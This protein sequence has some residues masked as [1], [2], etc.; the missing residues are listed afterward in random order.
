MVYRIYVE[1][2]KELANEAKSLLSDIHTLLGIRSVTDLRL[3][4]RY[5]AEDIDAALFDYA[6]KNVFSEPQLDIVSE[7][8]DA[9]GASVF[10]VEY[11][12]GQF[13]Q[14]ADSAA[15][16]IQ[17]ISQGERPT[18]KT[19][20]VYLLY[21]EV[22]DSELA[23]I[24]KYVIN[25]VE[26][27][28][29]SLE[30][31]ET[32]KTKYD[33]PTEVETLDGFTDLDEKGLA[34]FVKKYALAMDEDDIAFCRDYFRKEGRNPTITEIRMIDTYWSDHCR[35]TTFL[36]V[37]DSVKFEDELLQRTY[38]DYMATR[39]ELGRTKPVCLMDIGT[40]AGKY[41]KEKGYLDKLDESEEINACTVKIEVEIDGKKEPWLLLF[42]N[43]TH[44]HP[45]EIEPFGGA[46]TCI[47]GAIRDPLSGRSYV[48]GAMRVTGAS[49]PLKSVAETIP[50]KLPQRKIVTTAAAGYSSYGNQI[51][52]ATGI[53]DELYHDGYTAKRME[54]GAVIAAAP[55]ENV[56]RECPQDGDV[57]ILLGGAT[58]RDGCGG[59]T[60]SSKSHTTESLESC[61]AEVQKGNAPEERK[62]QR[63][64]RN[65]EA[66]RMIK[67]C[68]DFG[69]GGVSVAI[70]ELA[71][72]LEIDLN[73][74]PKK[75][76]GLDGTELAIS[77]SQERMAV[78]IEKENVED[79]LT[80]AKEENLN[81]TVVAKVK[82]EKRLTMYWNGKAI[83]DLSREF[84]NSNGA[85]KHI[86]IEAAASKCPMK[87]IEGNFA[88]N[89]KKLAGDLNV[90][91]K[92]GLS[93]RFDSTIGA[94]TVLMPFG[95]KNQL[96]PIQA[97]VQL[98]STEKGHTD[99]CSLMSWGYNPFYTE[100]TPFHGAYMAVVES[101]CKLIATGAKFE[102]VYLTFQEYFERP[103][104]DPKRW[105]KPLSAL[106]GAFKVQKDL[107]V[108]AIGG[109]DSMSG[110]FEN[111]D[112]PP[113]LVS[114]AVTTDKTS[115]I[116]S[117]EFKKAGHKLI[118]LTPEFD[119][120][121]LP[122]TKSLTDIFDK[123]TALLRSGKAFACYTPT[124]GGIAEAVMKMC[125]GNGLGFDYSDSI[126]TE[127]IFS[128]SYGSFLLEV[129]EDVSEGTLIGFVT[130]KNEITLG[131]E[132][133]DLDELLGI[134][135][136]KL[137]S[138]YSC[139]IDQSKSKVK[140]FSHEAGSRKAPAVKSAKPKVLIP[141]FPG[142]NC[143]FDS[144][145][146]MDDAGAESKI[147]VINNLTAD[148]IARSVEHFAKELESAQMVFIP[149]GFSGGDEPEGSAKFI[150]AFFRNAAVK[151]QVTALLEKRDGL[152]CG[153]C[154]G[155]QA[156]VKLGLVPYGKI[157]DARAD[158]PTLTFNTIARHQ[159]RIVRT[160]I[161]SNM[162]PWLA[163]T[164]VGDIYNVPIS[165]GEGRF[166]ADEKTILDLAEKG[167]IATQYVDFSGEATNDIHFNPNDSMY[168]IE[169]IT[170]PD[171]RVFGKMGHSERI[172]GG[173]YQNVPG[174][175]DIKMFKSAVKYFK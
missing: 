79:F 130:D 65:K 19:A 44:N 162:S 74:V 157:V 49:D 3:I 167:Q 48:Y 147:I 27:R 53:V 123:V 135:E 92:R 99:D 170:S 38:D 94:G 73:A 46:A 105:G 98:I 113:T 80:L 117:P 21:G 71:D 141:V 84:L 33:I 124:Y 139:N 156:L 82:E 165:H 4:N 102:D 26:A 10:A 29:A 83:V 101:V 57:V 66:C 168:A 152:M 125:L 17:I 161:A 37:I 55:A 160:R 172:A 15:Q 62:L 110:T 18:V 116:V 60:G 78:V 87:K 122:V 63:L 22:T 144:A 52:L 154:N 90:C 35:H 107:K 163:D 127:D 36:T 89:M 136:D 25:P 6:V 146:A 24:K 23:Q 119:S 8:L 137:E 143:E 97:M 106:L 164:N 76:E 14:R 159:S 30:K 45:T 158:M 142:T 104:K 112:V 96:T 5:D 32:L 108:A 174:E 132:K 47:G 75:Y 50:G 169:G 138:V 140:T 54:I 118:Q 120:D 28:E 1:K 115:H 56:R 67:R 121:H 129:E 95:G 88:D 7:A 145:K 131:G 171:G 175:Y 68:N 70:G 148:G 12:P 39:K 11:L 86:S 41:L 59:A 42:K 100:A 153:I 155:F 109:K 64:F 43:E 85:E 34:D 173:L 111:L 103:G 13:D 81:A 72:G 114:F 2:K 91:S 51:G 40:L 93:E 150:T 126:K 20:K 9:D 134:Y 16:C 151:E 149:G 58:G 61:G 31:A 166:L 133:V 128:Y 69:A 77:E